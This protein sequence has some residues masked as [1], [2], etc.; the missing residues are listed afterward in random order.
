MSTSSDIPTA[1]SVNDRLR[2]DAHARYL[3]FRR[4]VTC[5]LMRTMVRCVRVEI[6]PDLH[7]EDL[8]SLQADLKI[9]GYEVEFGCEWLEIS[10]PTED[11]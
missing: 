1:A 5:A 7:R 9:A 6:A 2:Q 4:E 11:A 8:R 10:V 3:Q